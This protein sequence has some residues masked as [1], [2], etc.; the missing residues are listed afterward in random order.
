[1]VKPGDVI[2]LTT[3]RDIVVVTVV[4]L[5]ERRGSAREAQALY[6]SVPLDA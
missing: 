2:T 3:G 6:Q 5:A 4:D 1:M